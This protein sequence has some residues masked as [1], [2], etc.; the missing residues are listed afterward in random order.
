VAELKFYLALKMVVN[1]LCKRSVLID[2]F[3]TQLLEFDESKAEGEEAT[4]EKEGSSK[5]NKK[6]D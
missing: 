4:D 2:Y 3:Y 6:V 1:P 5:E